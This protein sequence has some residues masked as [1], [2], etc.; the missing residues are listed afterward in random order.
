MN[1]VSVKSFIYGTITRV[2]KEAIPRGAASDSKN[3]VTKGDRIELRRGQAIL[4]EVGT[5]IN[6]VTGL[7]VGTRFNGTQIPF[8]THDRK[9]KYYDA[10]RDS[11]AVYHKR[12]IIF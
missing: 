12:L 2:E 6:P 5:G 1:P 3:W 9:I 8:K 10:I 4:G 7:F 11:E